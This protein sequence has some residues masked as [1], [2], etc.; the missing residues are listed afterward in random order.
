MHIFVTGS[1][2]FL[3][4]HFVCQALS[5]GHK[6]TA[7]RHRAIALSA[8]SWPEQP[9][10]INASLLSLKASQLR[11][12]DAIAHFAA[13][14]V[15]PRTA[16]WHELEEI[17]IRA[18]LNLCIIAKEIGARISIAGS[19]AEY[20]LSGNKYAFIPANAPLE[21]T[22]PYAASK[23][24]A[25]ILTAA[26]ARSERIQLAYLRIFNAYGEGQFKANLW[27]SMRSAALNGEDF[28]LTK[29]EQIRDFIDVKEVSMKFLNSLTSVQID[30]GNPL[31]ANIGSGKPQTIH[32]FCS[33]WWNTW[34]AEGK[35]LFGRVPYRKGEV[36]R[37]VPEINHPLCT[38]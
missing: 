23:A 18:T 3:G 33:F 27:P 21:P 31:I 32:D 38:P 35:L 12:V 19:F 8:I 5:E 7:L 28:P 26:F 11:G 10:W 2:G 14:G 25:S 20:G 24:A 4:S 30:S 6:I 37:Y 34:N 16:T 15:S 13:T 22:Y 36:M 1:T 29:G 9:L 17:N